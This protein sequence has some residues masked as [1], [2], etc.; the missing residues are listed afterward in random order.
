ME[1]SS[2]LLEIVGT[3]EGSQPANH[4]LRRCR[5]HT[6]DEALVPLSPAHCLVRRR[7]RSFDDGSGAKAPALGFLSGASV[8][9]F[10]A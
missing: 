10:G 6:D 9:P 7:L 2:A 8:A 3:Q 1:T 5:A 4:Y